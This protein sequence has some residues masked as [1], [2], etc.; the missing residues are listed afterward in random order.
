MSVVD[1]GIHGLSTGT[2]GI[3]VITPSLAAVAAATSGFESVE[4][5]SK[6][7]MLSIIEFM[8]VAAGRPSMVTPV[9]G[10]I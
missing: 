2:H 5:I 8:M 7:G 9:T 10:G 3:G 4:H 6:V 1:T